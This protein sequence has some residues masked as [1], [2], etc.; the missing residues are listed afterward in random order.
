MKPKYTTALLAISCAAWL[1]LSGCSP[2]G[3]QNDVDPARSYKTIT[4]EGCEYIYVSRRPW[5][6]DFSLTHKGNCV[7]PIHHA[8]AAEQPQ[9]SM[10]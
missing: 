1:L 6:G 3:S 8:R 4:I 7:N 10:K 2:S 9:Q 5:A